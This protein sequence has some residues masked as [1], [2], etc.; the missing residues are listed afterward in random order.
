MLKKMFFI[1]VIS[2]VILSMA[3]VTVPVKAASPCTVFFTDQ[4]DYFLH[5][6]EVQTW[7]KNNQDGWVDLSTCNSS[8][9]RSLVVY[10]A[11]IYQ[12]SGPG[13]EYINW[14]HKSGIK[15]AIALS[16]GAKNPNFST[17]QLLAFQTNGWKIIASALPGPYKGIDSID[18]VKTFDDKT[19]TVFLEGGDSDWLDYIPATYN[20]QSVRV[21]LEKKGITTFL[22]PMQNGMWVRTAIA[23][24]P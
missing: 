16:S 9:G 10:D 1:S 6:T 11:G 24:D 5:K 2:L 18:F 15:G 21:K 12:L 8:G 23:F 22:T 20:A 14:L 4:S 3:M 7:F 17:N 13:A 19:N